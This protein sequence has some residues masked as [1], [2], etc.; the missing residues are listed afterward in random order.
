MLDRR[1]GPM[2]DHLFERSQA[3]IEQS[4]LLIAQRRVILDQVRKLVVHLRESRGD[5]SVP[6]GKKMDDKK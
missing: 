6:R 5:A 4:R 3:A 1:F 2:I